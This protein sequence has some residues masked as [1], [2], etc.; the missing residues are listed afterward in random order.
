MTRRFQ[1]LIDAAFVAV[2]VSTI[3]LVGIAARAQIVHSVPRGEVS[4]VDLQI[5]GRLVAHRGHPMRLSLTT[6]EVLGLDRLRRAAG[7]TVHVYASFSRERALGTITSDPHG[8]V[9]T[10]IDVPEDAPSSFVVLLEVQSRSR[11]SRRFEFPVQVLESR[12]LEIAAAPY[13]VFPGSDF[14]V[15]GRLVDARTSRALAGVELTL[16]LSGPRGPVGSAVR[17]STDATGSFRRS[18]RIAPDAQTGSYSVRVRRSGEHPI[19]AITS[20]AVI[21]RTAPPLLV[22]IAPSH[23]IA[24]PRESIHL[25]LVVRRPD[26]RPVPG[27]TVRAGV[28][29]E[30]VDTAT[31]DARGRARLRYKTMALASAMAD[32]RVQVRVERAGLGATTAATTVRVH[33]DDFAGALSF[34]GGRFAE[35]L[36]GRAYLRAVGVDGRPVGPDVSVVFSGPRLR[37]SVTAKT[38]ESG[39]AAAELVLGPAPSAEDESVDSCG[40]TV[41]TEITA[42]IGEGAGQASVRRCLLLD[43]D[44]ILRVRVAHPRIRGGETLPVRV[45]RI[46][47]ASREPVVLELVSIRGGEGTA[48]YGTVVASSLLAANSS[49]ASLAVPEDVSGRLWVRARVLH[50]SAGDELRGA[51]TVVLVDPSA[52]YAIDARLDRELGTV[53]VRFDGE[54]GEP[55]LLEAL[56]VPYEQ[57]MTIAR[58]YDPQTQ[59]VGPSRSTADDL[60]RSASWLSAQNADHVPVDALAAHA[61]I[62][63]RSSPT[64]GPESPEEQGR[65][66]DPYR[67]RARFVQGRLALLFRALEAFVERSVPGHVETV[68]HRVGGRLVFNDAVLSSVAEGGSLGSEGATGLGGEPITIEQL[69]SIEPSFGYDAVARR[70]TRKRLFELLL[71]MRAFVNQRGFDLSWARPGDPRVWLQQMVES[72]GSLTELGPRTLVDGWGRPFQLVATTRPRFTL[73]QPVAGF[74]I[75]SAG[76]DGRFGNG[77]DVFDPTARVL[78][79]GSTYANAV[80]EDALVARLRGVELSRATLGQI[81]DLFGVYSP[82]VPYDADHGSRSDALSGPATQLPS[83]VESDPEPLAIRRIGRVVP[84]VLS[85]PVLRESGDARLRLDLGTEPMSW[86]ILVRARTASGSTVETTIRATTGTD[87]LLHGELPVRVRRDEPLEID[88]AATNLSTQARALEVRTT[89]CDGASVETPARIELGAELSVPLRATVRAARAMNCPI[90]LELREGDRVL[91]T[92]AREVEVSS[93][94]H[95][96]RRRATALVSRSGVSLDLAAPDGSANVVGRVTVTDPS[97][98]VELPEF[99]D[100]HRRDPALVAWARVATGRPFDDALR[101]QVLRVFEDPTRRITSLT[102]ALAVIALSA[103]ID[104]EPARQLRDRLLRELSIVGADAVAARS[105]PSAQRRMQAAVIASLALAGVPDPD[106]EGD[107][108]DGVFRRLLP[109]LRASVRAEVDSPTELAFAAA[110]LLLADAH[111]GHGRALFDRAFAAVERDGGPRLVAAEGHEPVEGIAA[112]LA[113]AVAAREVGRETDSLALA[114]AALRELPAIGRGEDDVPFWAAALGVYGTLANDAVAEVE[115]EIRGRSER[116]SLEDGRLVLPV[117]LGSG[118]RASVRVRALGSSLVI[119]ESEVAYDTVFA[120]ESQGP[121]GLSIAGDPGRAYGVSALEL[122]V[123]S[124]EPVFDPIVELELPASVEVDETLRQALLATGTVRSVELRRAGFLRLR[125]ASVGAGSTVTVPLPFVFAARGEVHGLAAVAYPAT[126]A[127]RR[128]V[129]PGRSL[130]LVAE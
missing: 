92:L 14:H 20:V 26:G 72:G 53:Q 75:V 31:T 23:T 8:R 86:G 29:T 91:A 49:E 100:L 27:A 79:S 65:L 21:A 125:L 88:L 108:I 39:V 64:P 66:R 47:A 122:T 48:T 80:L 71:E 81:G 19:E 4:G 32:E 24:R 59:Y 97:A 103:R 2:L 112:T 70:V 38:D 107:P 13:A 30:D 22:S 43:P 102:R 120:P 34:E 99:A 55:V 42:T 114:S 113:L 60:A 77:D 45:D 126:Q 111:D 85:A 83:I 84:S 7:A 6:F 130:R 40:G 44:G 73:L 56:A 123:T 63:G 95:P 82:D 93:G 74:E 116:R 51:G 3:A 25:D 35:A 18:Y 117:E 5:D 105:G 15:G 54:P 90:R 121:L 10:S 16:D 119:A 94:R 62:D 129:L 68:A 41:A 96:Q 67:A 58:S 36:P 76:P 46:G 57:A 17:I 115:V 109:S 28:R 61:I 106:S 124:S 12:S 89:A 37:S 104:D 101:D 1:K 11:V 9:L 33:A 50:G 78:A 110:A 87:M 128:T 127:Y 69:R 52:P 118:G 98:I